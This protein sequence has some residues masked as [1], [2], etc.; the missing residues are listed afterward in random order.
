METTQQAIIYVAKIG[1]QV[2]VQGV[3]GIYT[4]Q[5]IV[6]SVGDDRLYYEVLSNDFSKRPMRVEIDK[7]RSYQFQKTD[8]QDDWGDMESE[9]GKFD[10]GTNRFLVF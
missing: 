3:P 2:I 1:G 4:I 6:Y 10:R 9:Y 5:D 7:A 8:S